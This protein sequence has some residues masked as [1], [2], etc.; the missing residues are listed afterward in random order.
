MARRL[1]ETRKPVKQAI[2]TEA[3]LRLG[4]AAWEKRDCL[5]DYH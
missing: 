1:P 3:D 4:A 5:H 2:P